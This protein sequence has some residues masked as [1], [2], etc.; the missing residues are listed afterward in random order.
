MGVPP[1]LEQAQTVDPKFD[2]SKN[3]VRPN[4]YISRQLPR[5][6]PSRRPEPDHAQL[7]IYLTSEHWAPRDRHDDLNTDQACLL[8]GPQG[9]AAEEAGSP[10]TTHR[11]LVATTFLPSGL[12]G[13]KHGA[14][15][16]RWSCASMCCSPLSARSSIGHGG[17]ARPDRMTS[18]PEDFH[19]R[20]LP[21]PYVNLSI[22]TAPDVRPLP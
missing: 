8:K 10:H 4:I 1:Y 5:S 17:L 14:R 22:H 20:A 3:L 12:A 13:S 15:E 19:L 6:S 9:S 16:S 11:A 21:E 2:H 18:R 7:R